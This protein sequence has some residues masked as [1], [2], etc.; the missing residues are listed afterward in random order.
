M[1]KLTAVAVSKLRANGAEREIPD[2]GCPGLYLV[3]YKTGRKSWA[4]R[5]RRPGD[6]R[7]AKLVLGS[8]H[9]ITEGGRTEPDPVIGGHLTLASAR[10]LVANLQHQIAQGRDPAAEVK[11]RST[12]TFAAAAR[13]FIEQHSK[14][15]VRGWQEQA[16]LLG[17]R[18]KEDGSL[19]LIPKGQSERWR[20]K[21]LD[22][23]NEDDIFKVIDQARLKGVPGLKKKNHGPSESRARAMHAVLSKMFSWLAEKRRI[24]AN[25]NPVSE[26]KRPAPAEARE[27]ALSN[28]E[29]IKFWRAAAQLPKPFGDVFKLLLLTGCR[30]SEIAE[31]RRAELSEDLSQLTLPGERTKNHRSHV[32]PLSKLAREILQ[33]F[34]HK[35]ECEFVFSTNGKTPISGF[36][37]IKYQLDKLM[38]IP[39][40]QIHDLRRTAVTGMAELGIRPDVIEL[41]VNHISGARAGV[42]GIYNRSELLPERRE[43][44]ETWA[45]HVGRLVR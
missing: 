37:K 28:A 18:P 44:L 26:L 15:N 10:R 1:P 4:L 32:V 8:I 9:D 7:S 42:A 17:L 19:E 43:A 30:R 35:P 16:R 40:W 41:V 33:G 31:L 38:E 3:L 6:G 22:A 29:I 13:D 21:L 39:A 5:Y 20:N 14:S 27:R 25:A 2:A 23:I 24:R 36:S 11:L 34:E 45:K 12:D